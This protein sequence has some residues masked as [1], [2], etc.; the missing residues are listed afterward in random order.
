MSCWDVEEIVEVSKEKMMCPSC[1]NGEVFNGWDLKYK[2]IRT[3]VLVNYERGGVRIPA[4]LQFV[5]KC[6]KHGEQIKEV[7]M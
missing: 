1:V 7:Q 6:N 2:P 5:I 3:R 4:L